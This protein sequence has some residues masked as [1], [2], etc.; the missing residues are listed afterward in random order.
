MAA[1]QP[2]VA[3]ACVTVS[4]LAAAIGAQSTLDPT[5]L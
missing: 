1:S 4:E 5:V 2:L 3:P